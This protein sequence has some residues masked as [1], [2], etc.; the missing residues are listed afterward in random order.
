MSARANGASSHPP[1][2][3]NLGYVADEI[4]H[5]EKESAIDGEHRAVVAHLPQLPRF[6]LLAINIRAQNDTA[7]SR[8]I[9]REN[10]DGFTSAQLRN[11][12]GRDLIREVE[13]HPRH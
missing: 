13:L 9:R 1:R 3:R 2:G 6:I 8:Y 5:L 11:Y 7:T 12:A 10:M 4:A